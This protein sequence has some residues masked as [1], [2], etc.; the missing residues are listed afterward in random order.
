MIN[1]SFCSCCDSPHFSV[2]LLLT[3]YKQAS[4][5]HCTANGQAPSQQSVSNKPMLLS[6]ADL[7]TKKQNR[8][9]MSIWCACLTGIDSSNSTK[10]VQTKL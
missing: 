4:D 1:G 10:S 7:D 2:I 6:Y 3:N 5:H 9:H 8:P